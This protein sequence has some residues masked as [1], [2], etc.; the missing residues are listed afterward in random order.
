MITEALRPD[1]DLHDLAPRDGT[2]GREV[3]AEQDEGVSSSPP[4]SPRADEA[5]HADV[6]RVVVLDVFFHAKNARWGALSARWATTSAWAPAQPAPHIMVMR[7]PPFRS[8]AKASTS[9][10]PEAAR[11]AAWRQP[12]RHLG[13][14]RQQR[15]VARDKTTD[16]PRGRWR[17]GSPSRMRG[18]WSG[19]RPARRSA[20]W[21]ELLDASPGRSRRSGARDVGGDRRTG[22]RLRW[23]SNRP[24]I[25]CRLPARSFG[26]DGELAG[27]VRLRRR[28]RRHLLVPPTQSISCLPTV[29]PSANRQL[30]RRCAARRRR[31]GFRPSS[32]RSC[33]ACEAPSDEG[34]G[35]TMPRTA[36]QAK[37][38]DEPRRLVRAPGHTSYRLPVST[39]RCSANNAFIQSMTARTQA[40]RRRSRWTMTQ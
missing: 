2:G 13:V 40:A 4:R 6:E 9:H 12:A 10:Q 11:P 34:W 15:D 3:G 28:R 7:L 23:Q 37:L 38:A 18:I 14:G 20:H 19:L 27:E 35:G 26:A 5:G 33:A 17:Y 25:R 8:L 39:S 24:L 21:R 1:V 16:T 22:T 32:R 36:A 31:S 30:R 29:K